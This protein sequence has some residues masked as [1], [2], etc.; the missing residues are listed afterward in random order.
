M[1]CTQC[2]REISE[3][4]K[5]CPYC[6]TSIPNRAS[7]PN[8]ASISQDDG[9]SETDSTENSVYWDHAEKM[10][11]RKVVAAIAYVSFIGW[12][13]AFSMRDRRNT[14]E[15]FHVNQALVL[16]VFEVITYMLW[17]F[18]L[19]YPEVY[20]AFTFSISVIVGIVFFVFLLVENV[21]GFVSACKEK[22]WRVPLFGRIHWVK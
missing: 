14:F 20:T 19:A 15:C 9:V 21:V 11:G 6:G 17:Y 2:G 12:I 3:E 7:T 16:Y 13:V 18:P 4:V 1:F 22:M 8:G 5:F 10:H